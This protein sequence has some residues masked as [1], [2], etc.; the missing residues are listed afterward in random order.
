M[1]DEH[2]ISLIEKAPLASLRERDLAAIRVHTDHCSDCLRAFQ[3]SQISAL[4]LKERAAEVFE[5]SPFFHTRVMSTLRERQANGSWA[6]S[7]GL[8]RMWRAAGALASTMAATVA[9]LAVL[10]F[11]IPGSQVTSG[12]PASSL[13]SNYSAEEVLLN[14]SEQADEPLSDAQVLNT[15]YD[16]EEEAVR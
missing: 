10:T 12:P 3:A 13:S 1:R 4:L 8:G 5:P 14:Q 11:V 7:G 16:G 2:I 15:I 6:N 9:A